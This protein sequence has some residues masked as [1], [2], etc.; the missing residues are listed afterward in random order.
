MHKTR[1]RGKS[2][3]D[4]EDLLKMKEPI[5]ACVHCLQWEAINKQYAE[6]LDLIGEQI[7]SLIERQQDLYDFMEKTRAEQ[8]TELEERYKPVY[9]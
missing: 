3:H 4:M 5:G 8:E 9:R 2:F 6:I 1:P 7:H